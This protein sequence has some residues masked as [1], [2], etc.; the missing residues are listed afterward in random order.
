LAR[1]QFRVAGIPS[2]G[3]G[4]TTAV[5]MAHMRLLREAAA[6][7]LLEITKVRREVLPWVRLTELGEAQGRALAGL[8]SLAESIELA[9]RILRMP[10]QGDGWVNEAILLDPSHFKGQASVAGTD[11]KDMEF[12]AQRLEDVGGNRRIALLE[13]AL[14]LVQRRV[15]GVLTD[16]EERI[17]YRVSGR[18][19]EVTPPAGPMPRRDSEGYAV[20]DTTLGQAL[21]GMEVAAKEKP[22][23]LGIIPLPVSMGPPIPRAVVG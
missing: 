12:A 16:V 4:A 10:Y 23:E 5:R 8:P 20:Y 3:G 9:K 21:C 11:E 7:G 2:R 22:G 18:V 1:E 15:I 14:P 19:P 17:Y 6:D 13:L